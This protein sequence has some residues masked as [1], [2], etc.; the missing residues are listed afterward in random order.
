[1]K[2][3]KP[4]TQISK[5][6]FTRP[7]IGLFGSIE[8]GNAVEWQLKCQD[9]LKDLDVDVYNPRRDH[10]DPTW[11]QSIDNPQFK[12]QVEWELT[13]LENVDVKVF[14]FDPNTKSPVTL[15]ELGL[16][17]VG[18]GSLDTIVCCP[19]GFW[20]KGNVDIVC[21]R[22]GIPQKNTLEDGIRDAIS[23]LVMYYGLVKP[24][25]TNV[26]IP[27]EAVTPSLEDPLE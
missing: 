1:M 20:R 7:S 24:E 8:Q 15:M 4:P 21:A 22:Y 25:I 10:W 26:P 23:R 14:Y 6:S 9:W 5:K 2:L 27:V 11:N 16:G 19:T 12:E 13:A 17:A 3:I 18:A